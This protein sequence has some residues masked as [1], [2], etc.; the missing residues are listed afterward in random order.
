MLLLNHL[1]AAKRLPNGNTVI[2]SYGAGE[3]QV[4]LVEVT[5]DKQVVWTLERDS[6]PGIHEFQILDTN[7]VPVPGPPLK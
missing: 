4:K 2:S 1:T 3:H 6:K 7:G 5:R